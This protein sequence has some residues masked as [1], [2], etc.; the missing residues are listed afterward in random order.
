MEKFEQKRQPELKIEDVA[1]AIENLKFEDYEEF[2]CLGFRFLIILNTPE[3]L[4]A[5]ENKEEVFF[6][7]SSTGNFDIYILKTLTEQEKK[8]KVFHE[9][10]EASLRAQ[11]FDNQ[12]AHEEAKK[13]ETQYFDGHK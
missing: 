3:D 11:G 2:E 9:I 10:I 5:S 7:Q 6:T 13:A 8:R 12:Q 4:E 1:Q